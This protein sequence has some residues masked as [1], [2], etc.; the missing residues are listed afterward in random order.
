MLNHYH[1][2]RPEV[3]MVLG[4]FII[5]TLISIAMPLTGDDLTWGVSSLARYWHWGSFN[6]YDGRYLGNTM[7]IVLSKIQWLLHI[8]YGLIAAGLAWV[9]SKLLRSVSGGVAA[10]TA[11]LLM[12]RIVFAQTIGWNSGYINY[13]FSTLFTIGILALADREILNARPIALNYPRTF[14]LFL[15]GAGML[16]SWLSEPVTMLNLLSI[17][18]FIAVAKLRGG[19][20]A[21][22]WWAALAGTLIGFVLMFMNGGYRNS[23]AGTDSYRSINFSLHSIVQ[24]A[25]VITE[26]ALNSFAGLLIAFLLLAIILSIKNWQGW[27]NYQRVLGTLA[28]LE[29]AALCVGNHLVQDPAHLSSHYADLYLLLTAGCFGAL[30]LLL[31]A[32]APADLVSWYLLAAAVFTL[33]PYLALHPFGPRCVFSAQLFLVLLALRWLHNY[34]QPSAR[35]WTIGVTLA[36]A[37][38]LA[39]STPYLVQIHQGK[40]VREEVLRYEAKHPRKYQNYYP[41]IPHG[42]WFWSGHLAPNQDWKIDR[43][44]NLRYGAGIFVPYSQWRAH[45][46]E[47]PATLLKSFA[48]MYPQVAPKQ[49]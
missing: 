18:A 37:V 47:D 49:K 43:Y 26:T 34:V 32:L 7:I 29:L 24:N 38:T 45:R 19:H 9:C 2:R 42:D 41:E 10:M 14:A 11:V 25:K 8:V 5:F 15:A 17:I 46:H 44:Y 40:V 1:D 31:L 39:Y 13:V 28:T 35:V 33:L 36:A 30:A 27:R 12:P 48:R 23:I 3:A 6:V 16:S 21:R 4:V 20:L 22:H